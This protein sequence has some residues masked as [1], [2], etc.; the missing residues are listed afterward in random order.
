M[1]QKFHFLCGNYE[2]LNYIY[3]TKFGEHDWHYF[4]NADTHLSVHKLLPQVLDSL[5][6][7]LKSVKSIEVLL[8]EVQSI[9]YYR[10]GKFIFNN[11]ELETRKSV[12]E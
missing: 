5:V 7:K 12:F 11:K 1:K 10:D 9:N 8:D 4:E 6:G 3:A 2:N